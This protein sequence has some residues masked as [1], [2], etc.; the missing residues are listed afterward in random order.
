MVPPAV[1]AQLARLR[2]H[3]EKELV[4][5]EIVDQAQGW[6]VAASR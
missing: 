2:D 3:V 6:K 4:D 5:A 1:M